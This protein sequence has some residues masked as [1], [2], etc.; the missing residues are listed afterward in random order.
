[1]IILSHSASA[2]RTSIRVTRSPSRDNV[3]DIIKRL[4]EVKDAAAA[5]LRPLHSASDQ[6]EH[7]RR[8]ERDAQAGVAAV[9]AQEAALVGESWPPPTP[10]PKLKQ[11][12]RDAEDALDSTRRIVATVTQKVEAARLPAEQAAAKVLEIAAEIDPAVMAVVSEEGELAF[13]RLIDARHKAV[14]AESSVRSIA[15]A[16]ASRGWYR[17]AEKLSADLY[18]LPRLE[19][20]VNTAPYLSFIDRLKSDPD[21]TVQQ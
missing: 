16:M 21:A 18:S 1:L 20:S 12:R 19:A 4:D 11:A 7:A 5:A 15:L 17:G 10:S 3:A 8:S 13:A 2:V 6:Q 14:E 9:N